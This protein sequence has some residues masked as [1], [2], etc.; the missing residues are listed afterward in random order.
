[1]VIAEPRRALRRVGESWPAVFKTL[2]AVAFGD[3]AAME[4][5]AV[6]VSDDPDL[7]PGEQDSGPA[8]F[9][10]LA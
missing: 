3:D 8:A 6:P 1:M 2:L 7:L 9:F 10:W 5:A 4:R